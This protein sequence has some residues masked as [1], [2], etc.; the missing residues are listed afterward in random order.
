MDFA[1]GSTTVLTGQSQR[2]NCA[3]VMDV[4]GALCRVVRVVIVVFFSLGG[5][6][7]FSQ[8]LCRIRFLL[9]FYT[10]AKDLTPL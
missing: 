8:S 3:G 7:I 2:D 6:Y 9:R 5:G 1:N 10:D 4:F